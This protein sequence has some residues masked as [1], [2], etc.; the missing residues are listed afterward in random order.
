MNI[1][2][3]C[4]FLFVDH[5]DAMDL[6]V[7]LAPTGIVPTK[8]MTP[9]VPVSVSEI[10]EQ[11]HEAYELGI[12]MAHVHAR[13]PGSGEPSCSAKIYRDINEGIRAHAPDLIICVSLSGRSF[14]E[15]E[16]RAEPLELDGLAKPDMGSLTLA[17]L[18]FTGQASENS[19]EMVQALAAR[20][21]EKAI[22]PELEAFDLGM[23]NYA[24]YLERRGLIEPPHYFN[25]LLGNIASAQADL[26]HAGLMIRDLPSKSLWSLAGIGD[27]QLSMNALAVSC[28]GGVRVG[29]EDSIWFDRGRST[30][31]TNIGLVRRIHELASLHGR[32]IMSPTKLRN[33][34]GLLPGHGAYGRAQV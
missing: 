9:N 22:A 16:R 34:L 11:V 7:N 19:P 14:K 24:K 2:G 32:K 29:L 5:G 18:N 13:E 8:S 17:S 26:L 6:I 12:T 25:L 30:L 28:G 3:L 15:F 33:T 31:A 23:I 27:V 10:I 4:E 20:M 1:Q 21:Q